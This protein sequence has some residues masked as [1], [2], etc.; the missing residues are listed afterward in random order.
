MIK[1]NG[2]ADTSTKN[3]FDSRQVRELVS[4]P[5]DRGAYR[6][7]WDGHNDMGQA[8]ASGVY[9][10]KLVTGSFTDTKKMTILK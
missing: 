1:D 5:Q 4:G 7:V 6:V 2:A 9:F 10:Y 3:G 8:V